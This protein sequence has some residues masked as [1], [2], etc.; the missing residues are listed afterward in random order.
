MFTRRRLL[1]HLLITVC[2]LHLLSLPVPVHQQRTVDF[3]LLLVSQRQSRRKLH[4]F[5]YSAQKLLPPELLLLAKICTKSFVGWGFV[6]DPTAGAYSAPP[7][8]LAG[9]GGGTPGGR[10]RGRGG[11]GRG[12]GRWDWDPPPGTGREGKGMEGRMGVG[13]KGRGGRVNKHTRFKTSGA[14]DGFR[15]E[16]RPPKS[17]PLFSAL[18]MASPGANIITSLFASS[19]EIEK[20]NMYNTKSIYSPRQ[21][22]KWSTTKPLRAYLDIGLR[23]APYLSPIHGHEAPGPAGPGFQL[24]GRVGHG[25]RYPNS[26]LDYPNEFLAYHSR[27]PTQSNCTYILNAWFTILVVIIS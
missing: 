23:D 8:L 27:W 5:L 15:A 10:G 19:A 17:F 24:L 20:K 6:P 9:L 25:L 22:A 16:S 11:K 3:R 21:W 26:G 2:F 13:R 18:R 7:D 12:W 1:F 14:A 4:L